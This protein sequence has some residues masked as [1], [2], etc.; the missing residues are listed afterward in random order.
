[1]LVDINYKYITHVVF[2]LF[3]VLHE[4]PTSPVLLYST[5]Q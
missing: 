4:M 2:T 5:L 1:M 3:Q